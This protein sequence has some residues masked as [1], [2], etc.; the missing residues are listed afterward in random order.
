MSSDGKGSWDG[1]RPKT[2]THRSSQTGREQVSL[3]PSTALLT[4]RLRL[5]PGPRMLTASEI[6]LLRASKREM[7]EQLGEIH[8]TDDEGSKGEDGVAKDEGSESEDRA[9][10]N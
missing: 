8:A 4:Q 10:G 1:K 3:T 7:L 2:G 5:S 9:S 6:A